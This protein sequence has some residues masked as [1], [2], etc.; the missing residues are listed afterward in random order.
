VT[1]KQTDR[2]TNRCSAPP[3]KAAFAMNNGGVISKLENTERV[4]TSKTDADVMSYSGQGSG[5][6]CCNRCS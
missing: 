4:Q 2:Q 3:R 1:D 5:V 6:S